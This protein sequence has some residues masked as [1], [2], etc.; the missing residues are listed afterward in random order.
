MTVVPLSPIPK[1]A[2]EYAGQYTLQLESGAG[3]SPLRCEIPEC[4]ANRISVIGWSPNGLEIYYLADSLQERLSAGPSRNATIYAWNPNSNVVRLIHESG[5]GLWGRLYN[6]DGPG[7]LSLGPNLIAGREI[8]AAFAAADQ[9]PRVEAINL[10]SG[11]SRTLF[12]PNAEL[13]SLTHQRAIWR[14]WEASTGY[15]GRGVMFLPDDYQPGRKYPAVITTYGCG[16][17]FLRGGSG[18]NAP[19]FVLASQGF[20]AICVDVSVREIIAREGNHSRIYPIFCGAISGLIAD[21]TKSGNLDPARV[22]LTGQSLGANA[23][24][25]CISHSNAI[26]AAAFRHG[27]AYERRNGIYSMQPQRIAT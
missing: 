21:L 24:A 26:A 2:R 7:G 12:D 25:Y 9:P 22:G 3:A 16:N 13:R 1:I 8:V 19:E 23:G 18:D 11:H 10:D 20:I 15:L 17:G 5:S 14:T 27:S 6:L 4:V